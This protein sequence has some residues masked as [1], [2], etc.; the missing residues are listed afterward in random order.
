MVKKISTA[1][2]QTLG[3]VLK[4]QKLAK[5]IE[6]RDMVKKADLEGRNIEDELKL[7]G[8]SCKTHIEIVQRNVIKSLN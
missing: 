7:Y 4:K 5:I 8:N 2:L 1:Y 6:L 3:R